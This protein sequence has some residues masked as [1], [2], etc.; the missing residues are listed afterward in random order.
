MTTDIEKCEELIRILFE[1]AKKRD[2]F[3]FCC[4]LLRVRGLESPGWDP[5]SESSQ[6][7][8]QILSLIQAPVESSLRLRLTL[9]LYCHLTE[10]ND[11]YNIV[12]N[13]LRIIQGHRYTMNP[14]I[15]S[16]HKS[17]IEAR[18]PFSKTKRISEWANEVG[19]KEIG[20][21]FTL[22]LVKQVRNAFFHSDYILTNDSFNI[23]HGEPVKIG[24]IYQQVIPYSWL[25]P[26]LELGI[27]MGLFTINITLDNI[28]SYKKDKLVKGRLAADGGYIDIQLT[29]EK[30]YGLT[31][32]KTPPDEEL[33]KKA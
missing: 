15:A 16:L 20:E 21:F 8:Q 33:I 24:D 4:T 6:L 19:F 9:F 30:G 11:L 27:N 2:E 3:E 31:G 23:K 32:F 22:S 10:M 18:S 12:G 1:K 25:M 26:R 17:K 13:M 14:F 29:V 28:R 7:A 5:L